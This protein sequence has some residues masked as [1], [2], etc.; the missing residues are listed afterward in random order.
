[1]H[2][3]F[4]FLYCDGTGAPVEGRATSPFGIDSVRRPVTSGQSGDVAP[5]DPISTCR[6]GD[7]AV[8][9]VGPP[10][11]FVISLSAVGINQFRRNN[12]GCDFNLNY[13]L[14]RGPE[15][16]FDLFLQYGC[17]EMT[18]FGSVLLIFELAIS[19][20]STPQIAVNKIGLI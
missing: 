16:K 7:G 19:P 12:K 1:M 14:F 2:V 5:V 3:H 13:A 15:R 10:S 11:E 4:N 6:S 20:C 18:I 17:R 9:V 8:S